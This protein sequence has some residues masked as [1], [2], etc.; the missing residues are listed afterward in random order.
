MEGFLFVEKDLAVDEFGQK[1][2]KK[3]SSLKNSNRNSHELES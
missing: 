2:D 3:L 1:D